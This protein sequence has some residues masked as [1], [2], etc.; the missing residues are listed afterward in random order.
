MIS[1]ILLPTDFSQNANHAGF[2]AIELANQIGATKIVVYHTYDVAS[3][4]VPMEDYSQK[5][6]SEPFRQESLNK[7]EQL[8]ALLRTKTDNKI[9]IEAYQSYATLTDAVNEVA[10]IVQADLIVMGISAG[11]KLK[12][13]VVGSH[14]L[15]VAKHTNIPVLIVPTDAAYKNIQKVLLVSDLKDV[16]TTIPSNAI[17]VLLSASKAQLSVLHITENTNDQHTIEKEQLNHIFANHLPE[18]YFVQN[19]DFTAAVDEFVAANQIDLV[20]VVP[21]KHGIFKSIFNVNH[22][23]T[24]AFHS[25]VPLVV[26]HN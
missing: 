5:I 13:V 16:E 17:N 15:A 3:A 14:S 10:S 25:K 12:E 2:Y 18:Y 26:A 9:I 8:V 19:N 1:S 23:K 7:L 20:I 11:S 21:K 22:T 24:L 4:T 6:V